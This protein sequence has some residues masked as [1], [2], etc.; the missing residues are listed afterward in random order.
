MNESNEKKT[1]Y[2][3]YGLHAAILLGVVWAAVKYVNGEEVISA[4]QQFNYGLAPLMIALALAALIL[5]AVRFQLLL[6]PFADH[7]DWLTGIK[8]YVAGQGATVLPGGFTGS[9]E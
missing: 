1:N 8:A 6:Q 9:T 3:K 5:K 2:L 7:I 4:L